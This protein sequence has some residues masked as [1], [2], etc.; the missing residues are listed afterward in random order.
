M[1]TTHGE[2]AREYY[3]AY[4]ERY[5]TAKAWNPIRQ[6]RARARGARARDGARADGRATRC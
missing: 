4:Y 1:P 3:S 5:K 6:V 2:P